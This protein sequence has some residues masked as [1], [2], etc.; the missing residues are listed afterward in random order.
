MIFQKSKGFLELEQRFQ[1]WFYDSKICV[2]Y[3]TALLQGIQIIQKSGK[4]KENLREDIWLLAFLF[5]NINSLILQNR[6]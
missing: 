5:I 2:F 6:I 1:V 3:L 4:K